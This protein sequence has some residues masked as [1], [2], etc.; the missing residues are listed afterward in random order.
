MIKR[1]IFFVPSIYDN[2]TLIP[3]TNKVYKVLTCVSPP[4]ILRAILVM[5]AW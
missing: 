2:K 3:F 4:N 1:Y 5:I